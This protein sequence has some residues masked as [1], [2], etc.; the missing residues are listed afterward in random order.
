MDP[1]EPGADLLDRW[2][3]HQDPVMESGPAEPPG[4]V[5]P[6]VRATP[7]EVRAPA[8]DLAAA[9]GAYVFRPRTGGRGTLGWLLLV[10][11]GTTLVAGYLAFRERALV[12]IGVALTLA[13]LTLV[14]WAVR[15]GSA[16]VRMRVRNGVLE[17]A[18]GSSFVTF[19]LGN[20]HT[21]IEVVGRPGQRG[22]RVRL[23]RRSLPPYVIDR[24]MVDPREFMR[25]LATHRPDLA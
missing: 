7:A 1:A 22:W 3:A 14:V 5:P 12:E 8:D 11:A 17:I 10:V 25:V 16:V 6:A 21:P 24:T 19:D 2:F 18:R 13:A 15:A 23:V 4:V 20:P 9:P